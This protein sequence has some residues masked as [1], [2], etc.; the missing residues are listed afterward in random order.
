MDIRA[1]TAGWD[2]EIYATD[3]EPPDD[4]EGWGAP[5]GAVTEG[6]TREAVQLDPVP[7]T[8][9][10]IWITKQPESGEQ[11]G[12]YQMQISDVRIST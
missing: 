1:A 11:P 10:L 3:T 9:Y 8:S 5:I 7:A 12:R 6:G 4:L 2:A